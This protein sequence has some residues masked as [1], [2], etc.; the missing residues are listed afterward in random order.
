MVNKYIFL[1]TDKYF[2]IFFKIYFT[3]ALGVGLAMLGF[4]FQKRGDIYA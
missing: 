2:N 1:N 3:P 4:A